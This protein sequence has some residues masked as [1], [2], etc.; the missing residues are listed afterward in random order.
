MKRILFFLLLSL[1]TAVYYYRGAG[2]ILPHPSHAP[3]GKNSL[4]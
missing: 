1:T 2:G 4:Q 3:S